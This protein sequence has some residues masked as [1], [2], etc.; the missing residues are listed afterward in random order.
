[1]TT[2]NQPRQDKAATTARS[3]AGSL[4]GAGLTLERRRE[5]AHRIRWIRNSRRLALVKDPAWKPL[6][7][8]I[9]DFKASNNDWSAS[10][11]AEGVAPNRAE[12]MTWRAFAEYDR[13]RE[14]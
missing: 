8:I 9:A 11:P 2:N 10:T 1:M 4:G 3:F 5:I 13:V 6:R 12:E 7:E 14:F